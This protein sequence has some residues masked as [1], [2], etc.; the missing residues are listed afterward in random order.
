MDVVSAFIFE[1]TLS[2]LLSWN[3]AHACSVRYYEPLIDFAP[4]ENFD[5]VIILA[6][7]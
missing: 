5:R 7:E 4:G 2:S 1:N 6:K 3:M